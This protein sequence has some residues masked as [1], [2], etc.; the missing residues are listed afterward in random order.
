[1][2][3]RFIKLLYT[4]W[5]KGICKHCCLFCEYRKECFKEKTG[6]K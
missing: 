1:M 2:I 5:V 6:T 4:K 3:K